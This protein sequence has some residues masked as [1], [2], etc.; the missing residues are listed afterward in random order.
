[1]PSAGK[2]KTKQPQARDRTL[3]AALRHPIRVRIL[4]VLAERDIS[5]IEF[6]RRGYLP[7][8][9]EFKS[10]ASA[11]SHVS[12]HFKVLRE[13][14]CIVIHKSVPKRGSVEKVHRSKMLALHTEEDFK[15]LSEGDRIAITRSTL[16]MLFARAEGAVFQGTFDKRPDR[17]LSWVPMDVDDQGFKELV[18]LQDEALERAQGIKAAAIARK[19]ERTE[20]GVDLVETFPA[21]FGALAFESP[22]VPD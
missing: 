13:A 5:P 8:G 9:F 16:Q 17:H 1:M 11:E 3:C 6:V 10:E 19:H 18:D 12:Y 15:E 14:D 21:T 22:P 4:E 20:D 2:A 7:P